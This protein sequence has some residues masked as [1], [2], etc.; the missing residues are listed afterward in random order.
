MVIYNYSKEGDNMKDQRK[1]RIEQALNL[2]GMKRIELADKTGISRPT[3][4]NWINQ[5]YQPK[6]ESLMKMAQVLDVSEMWLAGY[7]VPMERPVEQKKSD[8][9]VQ[10]IHSMRTDED[11]KNLFLSICSL[12]NEQRKTI[13]SLV[14]ELSKV[15]SLH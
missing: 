9:L 11:L 7:D 10:L 12:T 3:I 2:R 1:N 4:S 13:K 14:N 5:K 6:Q 8:E 15:N